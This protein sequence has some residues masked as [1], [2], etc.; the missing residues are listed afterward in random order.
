MGG[1][2]ECLSV[3]VAPG[4]RD[5]RQGVLPL[6]EVRL[7]EVPPHHFAGCTQIGDQRIERRGFVDGRA[8]V[9]PAPRGVVAARVPSSQHS[10]QLLHVDRF[11]Q[12]IVH[13]CLQA[14][15]PVVARDTGGHGDDGRLRFRRQ[16]GAD[17]RVASMPSISGSCTSI[18]TRS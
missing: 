17:R 12:E 6:G 3:V 2:G 4:R 10:G 15:C 5:R 11:G 14:T 8:H 1:E 18:S 16:L 7:D 9:G 13:A